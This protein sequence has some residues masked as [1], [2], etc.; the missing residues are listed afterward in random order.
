MGQYLSNK[1]V[2]V[3]SVSNAMEGI[4][5]QSQVVAPTTD[6]PAAVEL[7]KELGGLPVT[8]NANVEQ[9]SLIVV[10]ADDYAGPAASISSSSSSTS[11]LEAPVGT[12][13]EDFGNAEVAPEITAGGSGPR[14][15]N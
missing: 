14:C 4:Y 9:G 10:V 5:S 15:V 1:G 12:P 7:A 13:G 6:D 2:T 8:A 11:T 3:A